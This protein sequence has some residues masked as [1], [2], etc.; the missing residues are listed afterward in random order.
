M[1]YQ[2]YIDSKGNRLDFVDDVIDGEQRLFIYL[3]GQPAMS[4]LLVD[5]PILG[6]IKNPLSWML[7]VSG[8]SLIVV[9]GAGVCTS[10]RRMG[11]SEHDIH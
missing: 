3:N 8:S 9:A 1:G 4:F 6:R 5:V 7:L 10:I 11:R 2:S